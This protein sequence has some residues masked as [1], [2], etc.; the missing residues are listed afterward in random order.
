[1]SNGSSISKMF[2]A[3][4]L[5]GGMLVTTTSLATPPGD[6]PA[7]TPADSKRESKKKK[8]N[9]FCQLEFTL[10][11]YDRDGAVETKTCLDEK[12]DKE[13][14]EIINKAKKKTCASPFCGCWLG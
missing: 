13:I 7:D 8:D 11:E 1:M 14:L 2:G 10:Y 12:S 9:E 5:G 4:V 6:S 3:L